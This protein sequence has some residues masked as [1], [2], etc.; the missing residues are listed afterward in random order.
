MPSEPGA[1]APAPE[2]EARLAQERERTDPHLRSAKDV[3]GYRIEAQDGTLGHV[4]SFQIDARSW[5]IVG[6]VID[7]RNWLPGKHVAVAP[8]VVGAI[9]WSEDAVVIQMR[10]EEL[11]ALPAY[12]SP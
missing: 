5:E 7:T 6:V 4:E 9:D 3:R 2:V 1:G 11:K 12:D 8:A 10:K